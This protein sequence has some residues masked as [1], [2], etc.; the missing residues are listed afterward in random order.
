MELETYIINKLP[1][2]YKIVKG[3]WTYTDIDEE[4]VK[5]F[6]KEY[7]SVIDIRN[8]YPGYNDM[9]LNLYEYATIKTTRFFRDI[10][11]VAQSKA[12]NSV[13]INNLSSNIWFSIAEKLSRSLVGQNLT[14]EKHQVKHTTKIYRTGI[15]SIN[16]KRLLIYRTLDSDARSKHLLADGIAEEATHPIWETLNS[17][18]GEWNCRCYV[19]IANPGKNRTSREK[20]KTLEGLGLAPEKD[21]ASEIKYESEVTD[22]RIRVFSPTSQMFDDYKTIRKTYSNKNKNK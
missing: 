13:Y 10:H 17:Y 2:Y 8:T 3:N 14:V 1:E 20:L 15:D 5:M 16:Q 22:S 19:V 18:L 4:L 7:A 6:F 9:L 12:Q 11:V 21:T